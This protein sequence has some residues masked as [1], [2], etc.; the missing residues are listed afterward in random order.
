MQGSDLEL[1]LSTDDVASFVKSWVA[2]ANSA[3]GQAATLCAECLG[4]DRCFIVQ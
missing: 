4:H 1:V 2:A 3:Q